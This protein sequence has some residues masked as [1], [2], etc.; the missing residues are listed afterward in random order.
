MHRARDQTQKRPLLIKQIPHKTRTVQP[1][2]EAARA[3]KLSAG[4]TQMQNPKDSQPSREGFSVSRLSPAPSPLNPSLPSTVYMSVRVSMNSSDLEKMC[5]HAFRR[6][7]LIGALNRRQ[8]LNRRRVFGAVLIV[9]AEQV[10]SRLGNLL[11]D[12]LS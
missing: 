10:Y 7:A 8:V 3:H 4:P 2:N 1:T 5:L 9:E 12:W 6:I 11:V